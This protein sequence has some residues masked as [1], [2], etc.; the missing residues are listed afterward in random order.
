MTRRTNVYAM[1]GVLSLLWGIA[2]VG[3]KEVLA[4]L[5][6][7]A[8]TILRFAIADACLLVV[9]AAWPPARPRL[10]RE[11]VWRLVVLGV[12]GVPGYH[13]ALNWGE[14]RTSASVASLIVA[15][16]PVMVALGS[17]ALLGERATARRWIGIALAFAGV[18]VLALADPADGVQTS[19][20]GVLVSVIA[21]LM[22]AIYVIVGKPLADR[23]SAI[24]VTAASMLI[25][26]L[27]LLP[28]LRRE[29]FEEIGALSGSGWLWML[30]L[31]IGSSVAGYFIF[32]WAL[33]EM[34]ATKVSVFL[35]AVPVVA[36]IASWLILD[37]RLG[38]SL[39]FA[40]A[41]VITGVVLAQQD[42]VEGGAM[43]ALPA[44]EPV[45]TPTLRSEDS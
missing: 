22:W 39:I 31:G 36:L 21:P 40:A 10:R 27:F 11:D 14:Q 44:E 1:L 23:A 26:S 16:A 32:V 25:G 45:A 12:T 20:I 7:A 34:E 35:Y 41:M 5:S 33:G 29:T 24:Q 3:I 30:L 43:P 28:L 15:T 19:V 17:A 9:M 38:V 6:P 42:K 37:E 2:F 8:L 13:L 18:A 4:E